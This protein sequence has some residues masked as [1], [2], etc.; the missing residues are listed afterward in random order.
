MLFRRSLLDVA[1]PFPRAFEQRF[2]DHWLARAARV[3][4][5]VGFVDEPLHDYVQHGANV[6]RQPAANR[7][8]TAPAIV[9]LALRCGLSGRADPR[10]VAPVRSSTIS[11]EASVAAQ[12]LSARCPRERDPRWLTRLVSFDGGQLRELSQICV[13]HV[14]DSRASR[15][16]REN[17]EPALFAGRSWAMD[18]GPR[19]LR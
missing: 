19:S 10:V 2:H 11:L 18:H 8:P 6:V 13:D 15:S 17:V 9:G 3:A 5:K 4:G 12:L 14:R 1:L 7:G 16:R